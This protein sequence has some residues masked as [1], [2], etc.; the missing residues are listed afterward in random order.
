MIARAI[1]VMYSVVKHLNP[2]QIPLLCSWSAVIVLVK[3]IERKL[4][5]AYNESLV[6]GVPVGFHIE[7]AAFKALGNWLLG[8]RWPQALTN[9]A[10][11]TNL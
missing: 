7:I 9:A 1:S 5:S 4:G 6:V 10:I 2:S 8:S 11:K 3:Q